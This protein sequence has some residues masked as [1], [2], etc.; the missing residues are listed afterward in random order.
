[1]NHPVAH[2]GGKRDLVDVLELAPATASKVTARRCGVVGARL[3]AA[4]RQDHVPRRC[5]GHMPTAFGNPVTFR[6][7]AQDFVSSGHRNRL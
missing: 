1:M 3:H 4:V 2:E 5:E 6:R 7:N